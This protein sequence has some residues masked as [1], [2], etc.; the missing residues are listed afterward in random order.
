MYSSALTTNRPI[1][2]SNV[3]ERSMY[4]YEAIQINVIESGPYSISS[5]SESHIYGRIYKNDFDPFDLNKNR[6]LKD[7]GELDDIRSK[8]S[9]NLLNDTIYIL[10]VSTN[11]SNVEANFSIIIS[12][13]NSVGFNLIGEYCYF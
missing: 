3:C 4:Y 12:G 6:Y 5:K 13:L 2:V 10:V 7:D 1:F 9:T 8:F 11:N